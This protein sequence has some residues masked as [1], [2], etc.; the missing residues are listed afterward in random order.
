MKHLLLAVALWLS[1]ALGATAQDTDIRSTIRQQLDAFVAEDVEQA[2]QFASPT[3]KNVFRTPQMFGHMVQ[4]GYPMVWK[5]G[6]VVFLS[7]EERE[8]RLFQNV[9]I[10]DRSGRTHLLEYKMLQVDGGWQIDGVRLLNIG[11][12]A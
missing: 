8:G 4:H 7:L 10:E 11:T 1:F 5:P 3:I 9:M 6:P 12:V 2:F